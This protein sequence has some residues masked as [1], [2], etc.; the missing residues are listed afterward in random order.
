MIKNYN[1]VK[2]TNLTDVI[3]FNWVPM[4]WKLT[5]LKIKKHTYTETFKI[6]LGKLFRMKHGDENT[7]NG[8]DQRKVW[9]RIADF[10]RTQRKYRVTKLK[11]RVK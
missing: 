9:T 8:H 11:F 6:N 5:N 1:E 2:S 4:I 7:V 3:L 10:V